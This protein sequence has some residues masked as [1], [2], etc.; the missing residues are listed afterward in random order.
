MTHDDAIRTLAAERY[1]LDELSEQERH[2]FEAHYFDCDEC[3]T[4]LRAGAMLIEGT[5][6][7]DAAPA[8]TI[9]RATAD[10]VPMRSRTWSRQVWPLAAAA[11]L[12]LVAGYQSFV[13]I[14]ALRDRLRPQVVTPLVLTPATRGEDAVIDGLDG[15]SPRVLSLDVTLSPA[16]GRLVYD[17][18]TDTGARVVA[19]EV[20]APLPGTPLLLVLA[21]PLAAGSYVVTLGEAAGAAD[22]ASTYHF[23]VR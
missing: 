13:A 22:R 5:R 3:A 17:V 6:R 11:G 19:G 7:G 1:A 8:A 10:V 23:S 20:P 4:D 15:S 18:R 9:R 2:E 12:A 14:P 21:E 16:T